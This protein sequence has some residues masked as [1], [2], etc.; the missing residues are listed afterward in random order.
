MLLEVAWPAALP[1]LLILLM[2]ALLLALNET[3]DDELRREASDLPGI[4]IDLL[5]LVPP[6]VPS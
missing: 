3:D 2:P 4:V 6:F 1:L 5:V